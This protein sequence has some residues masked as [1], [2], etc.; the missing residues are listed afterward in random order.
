MFHII[1]KSAAI[2]SILNKEI[3]EKTHFYTVFKELNGVEK[4]EKK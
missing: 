4:I 2:Y 1:E 3:Q